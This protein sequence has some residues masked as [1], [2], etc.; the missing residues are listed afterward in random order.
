[1]SVNNAKKPPIGRDSSSSSISENDDASSSEEI[2]AGLKREKKPH[3][4]SRPGMQPVI[5]PP[6]TSNLPSSPPTLS[7]SSRANTSATPRSD[8]STPREGVAEKKSKKEEGKKSAASTFMKKVGKLFGSTSAKPAKNVA[9][10]EKAISYDT[11]NKDNENPLLG[12]TLTNPTEKFSDLTADAPPRNPLGSAKASLPTPPSDEEIQLLKSDL[13]EWKK[14]LEG[15]VLSRIS[16]EAQTSLAHQ[17]VGSPEKLRLLIQ[18][19]ANLNEATRFGESPLHCACR[20]GET[21]SVQILLEGGAKFPE[22]AQH[23]ANLLYTL[24]NA[25]Y[26]KVSSRA[27]RPLILTESKLP[28]IL[29]LIK[30]CKN[31]DCIVSEDKPDTVLTLAC[32]KRDTSMMKLLM[33]HGASPD[34]KDGKGRTP[35]EIACSTLPRLDLL[36]DTLTTLFSATSDV[37]KSVN[38]KNN[39]GLTPLMQIAKLIDIPANISLSR[40]GGRGGKSPHEWAADA[41]EILLNNGAEIQS[42]DAS[43]RSALYFAFLSLNAPLIRLLL[44]HGASVSQLSDDQK[45]EIKQYVK[46]C[47]GR[48]CGP[49]EFDWFDDQIKRM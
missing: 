37:K 36:P 31:L 39:D 35:L 10:L 34:Y 22:D 24:M 15:D 20:F 5:L 42:V 23:Q 30:R 41:A 12:T 46:D 44:K 48:N 27:P 17:V 40:G 3:T 28:V 1:M 19:G 38:K 49:W 21:E 25:L 47:G 8:A 7:A 26:E 14:Q 16:P 18:Y 2:A 4:S 33:E 29:S 6:S 45:R 32:A 11:S 9:T 13:E 43:G